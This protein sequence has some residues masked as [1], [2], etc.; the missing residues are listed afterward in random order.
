MGAYPHI[1][2]ATFLTLYV[3]NFLLCHLQ[4]RP[5]T[6]TRLLIDDTV[7]MQVLKVSVYYLLYAN[8]ALEY[9]GWAYRLFRLF[10]RLVS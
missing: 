4:T 8:Q 1:S 6:V 7:E 5:V 2:Q 10:T 3:P 9:V